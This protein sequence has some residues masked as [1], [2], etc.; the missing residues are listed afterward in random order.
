M[1]T[2]QLNRLSLAGLFVLSLAALLT[3]LPF[4]LSAL[5]TGHIPTPAPDEGAGA[6]I[7]QLSIAALVP[8]AA[9][10]LL[11]A[12]WTQ[13]IS[14]VKRLTLPVVSLVLAFGILY[15]VEKVYYPAHY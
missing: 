1:Q 8:V 10:F 5:L 3:V 7:F 13:P 12:D 15:Y 2:R 6:H 9:L 4:V 14:T 11:T